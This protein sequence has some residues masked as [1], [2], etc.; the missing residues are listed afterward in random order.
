MAGRI[1]EGSPN[2]EIYNSCFTNNFGEWALGFC[3]DIYGKENP[4]N[5]DRNDHLLQSVT[6]LDLSDRCIHNL[7]CKVRMFLM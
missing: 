3:A 4:G 7:I 1:L 6:C 5:I 2:L